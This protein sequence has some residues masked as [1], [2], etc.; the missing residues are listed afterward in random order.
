MKFVMHKNY[1]LANMKKKEKE[2]KKEYI[3]DIKRI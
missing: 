3:K 1:K 2:R